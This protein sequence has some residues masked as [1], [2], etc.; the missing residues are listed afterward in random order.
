MPRSS[1][2]APSSGLLV[3]PPESLME[4]RI[5]A[6]AQGHR[7]RLAASASLS[8]PM[9]PM[10]MSLLLSLLPPAISPPLVQHYPSQ[11]SDPTVSHS[12]APFSY[13][14][15][16]PPLSSPP[17]SHRW[18]VSMSETAVVESPG[19]PPHPPDNLR[20]SSDSPRFS[21]PLP[22]S[23]PSPLDPLHISRNRRS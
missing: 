9:S 3:S 4:S 11:A 15:S 17:P 1:G 22:W 7:V 19:Q 14:F 10:P 23:F 12:A 13:D 20:K 6:M 16:S 5:S 8:S 18:M 21:S 2:E